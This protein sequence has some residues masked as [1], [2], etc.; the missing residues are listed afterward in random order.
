VSQDIV[1]IEGA[2]GTRKAVHQRIDTSPAEL[3]SS[4]VTPKRDKA[5]F[6]KQIKGTMA[7]NAKNT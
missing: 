7:A 5:I 4:F 1:K 3:E 2:R 6:L